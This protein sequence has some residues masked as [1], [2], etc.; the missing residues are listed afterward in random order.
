MPDA[1]ERGDKPFFQAVR[2]RILV[3]KEGARPQCGA[4]PREGGMG[5]ERSCGKRGGNP[6]ARTD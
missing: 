1:C 3:G 2:L 5:C 6:H 4:G